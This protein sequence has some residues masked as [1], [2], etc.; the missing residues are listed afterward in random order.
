MDS[1]EERVQPI[2][3]ELGSGTSAD[4]VSLVESN[5]ALWVKRSS[6]CEFCIRMYDPTLVSIHVQYLTRSLYTCM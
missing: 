4:T 6:Q 5:Y 1:C 3:L 2:K